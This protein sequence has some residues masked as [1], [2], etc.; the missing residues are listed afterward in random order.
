MG[1]AGGAE[2][3]GLCVRNAGVL[4]ATDRGWKPVNPLKPLDGWPLGFPAP[5]S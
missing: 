3:T 4:A 1:G 2:T 5:P